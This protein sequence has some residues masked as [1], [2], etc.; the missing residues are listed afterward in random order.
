MLAEL[1]DMMAGG[2]I[3]FV[4]LLSEWFF[5]LELAITAACGIFW[6]IQMNKS[7]GLYDPLFIIPLLQSSYIVFATVAGGIYFQACSTLEP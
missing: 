4:G 5:W 2:A 1:F 7:L 6:A 3:S